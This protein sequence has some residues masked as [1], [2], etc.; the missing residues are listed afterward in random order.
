LIGTEEKDALP[1]DDAPLRL[2]NVR[3]DDDH[4][5]EE[6]LLVG[7]G[8]GAQRIKGFLSNTDI[9]HIMMAAY[10]WDEE[11]ASLESTP[12]DAISTIAARP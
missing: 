2:K 4:T 1:D 8:P 5:G 10:G 9:F 7:Q 6:V 3:R 11:S 12:A